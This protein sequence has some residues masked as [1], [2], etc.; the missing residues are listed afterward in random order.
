[1]VIIGTFFRISI[2]HIIEDATFLIGYDVEKTKKKEIFYNFEPQYE[3]YTADSFD[4]AVPQLG[5]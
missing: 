5:Q 2:S 3:Q 4:F 1:M